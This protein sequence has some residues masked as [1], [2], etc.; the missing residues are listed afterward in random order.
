M[1]DFWTFA[2]TTLL[3]CQHYVIGTLGLELAPQQ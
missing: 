2:K 1:P 3:R